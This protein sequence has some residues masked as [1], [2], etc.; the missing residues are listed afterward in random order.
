LGVSK[1]GGVRA[2]MFAR[3]CCSF[4]YPT[5]SLGAYVLAGLGEHRVQN[6]E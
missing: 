6:D 5:A 3:I 1:A 2:F 4:A